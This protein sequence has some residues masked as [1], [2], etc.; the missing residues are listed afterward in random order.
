MADKMYYETVEE[1]IEELNKWRSDLKVRFHVR[2]RHNLG[3]LSVYDSEHGEY[4]EIDI[5]EASDD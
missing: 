3:C 4:L 1:F 2:E 5:G